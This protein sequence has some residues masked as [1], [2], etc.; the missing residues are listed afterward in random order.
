MDGRER[1]Q[2]KNTIGFSS[3]SNWREVPAR[4]GGD[5]SKVLFPA[6]CEE[7]RKL[8]KARPLYKTQHAIGE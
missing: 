7:P 5:V 3:R 4:K 8:T 1:L 2:R 6:V